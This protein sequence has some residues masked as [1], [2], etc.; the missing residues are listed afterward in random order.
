MAPSNQHN[1]NVD[2]TPEFKDIVDKIK[3]SDMIADDEGSL[4]DDGDDSGDS[5]V[6]Y[7]DMDLPQMIENFF[8]EPKKGRNIPETLCEIKRNLEVH[9]KLLSKLVSV[10]DTKLK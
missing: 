5:E 10:I 9:N 4:E 6:E 1:V 3:L 8:T 2:E 7:E